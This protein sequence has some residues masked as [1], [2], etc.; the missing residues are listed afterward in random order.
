M[1]KLTDDAQALRPTLFTGVPRVFDRLQVT[2]RGQL[3]KAS[4]LRRSIFRLAYSWKLSN[5]RGGWDESK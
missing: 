4:W 1:R 5:M 2:V 3:A